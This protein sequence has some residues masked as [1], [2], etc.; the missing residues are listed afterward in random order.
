MMM[1]NYNALAK[2][3]VVLTSVKPKPVTRQDFLASQFH[4][5]PTVAT[6]L[7]PSYLTVNLPSPS[8]SSKYTFSF[9]CHHHK[10][11]EHLVF[12]ATSQVPPPFQYHNFKRSVSFI[13]FLGK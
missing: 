12:H 13:K 6:H 2:Y 11:V 1:I 3:H 7:P 9:K 4:P 8:W 5:L 10:P